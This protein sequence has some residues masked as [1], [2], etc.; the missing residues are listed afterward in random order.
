MA[1]LVSEIADI[2]HTLSGAA[3]SAPEAEFLQPMLPSAADPD[4]AT[5]RAKLE[6]LQEWMTRKHDA[7]RDQFEQSG[8]RVPAA[9]ARTAETPPPTGS[10]NVDKFKA[11]KP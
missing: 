3:V 8:Y 11:I 6:A 7:Y 5:V 1:S 9:L 10:G 2:R 4:V